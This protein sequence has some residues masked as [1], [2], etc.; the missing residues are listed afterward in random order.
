MTMKLAEEHPAVLAGARSLARSQPN[1]TAVYEDRTEHQKLQLRSRARQ[2]LEAAFPELTKGMPCELC[3]AHG[4]GCE[5]C[6]AAVGDDPETVCPDCEI[7]NLPKGLGGG[8]R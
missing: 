4:G 3:R 5:T 7:H 6:R 2:V 1:S 8:A